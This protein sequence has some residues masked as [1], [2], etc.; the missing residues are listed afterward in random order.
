MRRCFVRGIAFR[1]AG[2]C[3]GINQGDLI[4]GETPLMLVLAVAG[5]GRLGRHVALRGNG[6]NQAGARG[7]IL[8]A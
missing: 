7:G 1:R 3:P 4:A 6:R 2:F 8:I 5:F